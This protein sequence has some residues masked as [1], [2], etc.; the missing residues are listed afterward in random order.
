MLVV[1]KVPFLKVLSKLDMIWLRKP[2][3]A[4]GGYQRFLIGDLKY[5]VKSTIKDD[6]GCCEGAYPESLIKI[7]HDLAEKA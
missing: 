3:L 4:L 6:V 2:N 5:W 1:T 7:G